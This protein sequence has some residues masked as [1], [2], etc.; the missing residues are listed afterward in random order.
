MRGVGGRL[1]Y[2]RGYLQLLRQ[3]GGIVLFFAATPSSR[4]RRCSYVSR[5]NSIWAKSRKAV[6]LGSLWRPI[7]QA[8]SS[9]ICRPP[10]PNLWPSWVSSAPLWRDILAEWHIPDAA[11]LAVLEQA[12]Q[13]YDRAESLRRQIQVAG[14][15][16]ETSGG[17]V[18]ANPL[19]MAELQARSLVARL[20]GSL[21]CREC[22]HGTLHTQ[23]KNPPGGRRAAAT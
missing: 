22:R 4:A 12:S 23:A 6:V 14:E 2:L 21:G 11:L 1:G 3:A 15:L 10:R 7:N 9:S 5:I 13:G 16:I 8:L 18:K 19:I 20:L 17:A